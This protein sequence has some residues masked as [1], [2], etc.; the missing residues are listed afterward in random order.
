[1]INRATYHLHV[2]GL[3]SL[4][5]ERRRAIHAKAPPNRIEFAPR[6]C[7]G[8]AVKIAERCLRNEEPRSSTSPSSQRTTNE[9]KAGVASNRTI[10]LD[11][12]LKTRNQGRQ[13]HL[14]GLRHITNIEDTWKHILISFGDE[15]HHVQ[16]HLA[17]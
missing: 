15:N 16:D 17:V 13:G 1:M 12:G 3:K 2:N 7:S 10:L 5:S 9:A 8:R 11:D 6:P 4:E 14:G